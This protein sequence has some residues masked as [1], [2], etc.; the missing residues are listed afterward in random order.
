M[1]LTKI[2]ARLKE[3]AQEIETSA[4]NHY[5]IIGAAQELRAFYDFA[6][7][8]AGLINNAIPAIQAAIPAVETA[9]PVV[10]EAVKD[11][12]EIAQ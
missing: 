11:V 4:A 1:D 10:E 3:L 9:L 7:K 5:K 12:I 6:M 8:E 2:E